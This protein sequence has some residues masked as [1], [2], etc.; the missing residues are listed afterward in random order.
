MNISSLSFESKTTIMDDVL[1]RSQE[2]GR[3]E[4]ME[5]FSRACSQEAELLD[6]TVIGMKCNSFAQIYGPYK[7]LALKLLPNMLEA[8][9][10]VDAE[11][12]KMIELGISYTERKKLLADRILSDFPEIQEF[13]EAEKGYREDRTL[14]GRRQEV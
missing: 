9:S 7:E 10:T 4:R 6:H 3:F 5:A 11:N 8:Y 12:R 14:F 1:R 2:L 13:K